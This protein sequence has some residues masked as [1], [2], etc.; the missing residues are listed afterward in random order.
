MSKVYKTQDYL[1][2]ELS[3]TSE[4]TSSD[5]VIKYIDPNGETGEWPAI[6]NTVDKYI[7]YNIPAG[8]PLGISGK[9]TVWSVVTMEDTRI[10]P[11]EVFRFTIYEEGT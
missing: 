6:N 7:Y 3:Y 11:G 8:E 2:I 5:V 9:W 10:L 1:K 4:I